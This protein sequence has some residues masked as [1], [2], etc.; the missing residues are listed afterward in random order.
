MSD[1]PFGLLVFFLLAFLVVRHLY[2]VQINRRRLRDFLK[3]RNAKNITVHLV[4]FSVDKS[5]YV[6]E[7]TYDDEA[8]RPYIK[9][10]K[11]DTWDS[12]IQWLDEGSL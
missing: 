10:C 4:P 1:T 5:V 2:T 6:Y 3:K 7:V 8:G 9:K 11:L 12:P